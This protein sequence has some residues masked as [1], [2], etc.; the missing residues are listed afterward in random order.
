MPADIPALARGRN[1]DV[2]GIHPHNDDSCLGLLDLVLR[3]FEFLQV[4]GLAID[5]LSDLDTLRLDRE[6]RDVVD[7]TNA[8][9]PDGSLD[10]LGALLLRGPRAQIGESLRTMGSKIVARAASRVRPM[11]FR[12]VSLDSST[13]L[14]SSRSACSSCRRR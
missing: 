4:R 9:C 3:A 8:G 12:L 11:I 6:E 7:D 10:G 13:T 2:V 14:S 1:R 5:Q